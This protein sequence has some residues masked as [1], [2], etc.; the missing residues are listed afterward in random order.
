MLSDQMTTAA[1]YRSLAEGCFCLASRSNAEPVRTAY[2]DLARLC[3]ETASRAD[4]VNVQLRHDGVV[5][6]VQ[7]AF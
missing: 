2:L 7:E 5:R 4:E 3:L 6:L 1:D